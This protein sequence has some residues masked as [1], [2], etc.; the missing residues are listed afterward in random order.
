MKVTLPYDPLWTPL[1]W[2]KKY[3]P[4]YTTNDVHCT[5]YMRYDRSKIDYFF[6]DDKDAI[7]FALRWTS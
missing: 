6:S 5:G 1:E 4:S 3:C 7:W 2:A